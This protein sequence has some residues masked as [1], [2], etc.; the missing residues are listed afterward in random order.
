M[1]TPK[2]PKK[3]EGGGLRWEGAFLLGPSVR[4]EET[5]GRKLPSCQG[6]RA[7]VRSCK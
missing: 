2:G 1:A 3:G 5:L 4:A 7:E 6:G